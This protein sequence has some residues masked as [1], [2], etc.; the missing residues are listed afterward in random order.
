MILKSDKIM[1][2]FFFPLIA[3]CICFKIGDQNFVY[4]LTNCSSLKNN[5]KQNMISNYLY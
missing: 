4:D 2:Y 5:L 1:V 3:S